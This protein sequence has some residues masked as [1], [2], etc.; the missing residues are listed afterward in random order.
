[1]ADKFSTTILMINCFQGDSN[2]HVVDA[3][4]SVVVSDKCKPS[5]ISALLSRRF[6]Y[7]HVRFSLTYSFALVIVCRFY[8]R[9]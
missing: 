8:H 4:R 3:V 2:M 6:A 5:S 1:M 7:G 9:L